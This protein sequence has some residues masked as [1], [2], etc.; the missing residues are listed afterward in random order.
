MSEA[1]CVSKGVVAGVVVW[2]FDGAVGETVGAT[3]WVVV[4]TVGGG[5]E[6]VR[7]DDVPWT[8]SGGGGVVVGGGVTTV[9]GVEVPVGGARVVVAAAVEVSVVVGRLAS[10][11]FVGIDGGDVVEGVGLVAAGIDV[12]GC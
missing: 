12:A 8:N 3:A 9:A 6:V 5:G 1:V 4:A 2:L 7:G 10:G 11:L